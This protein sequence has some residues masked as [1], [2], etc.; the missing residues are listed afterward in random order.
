M[1][2]GHKTRY[3]SL[4]LGNEGGLG[5]EGRSSTLS[6]NQFGRGIP[7][8]NNLRGLYD[9]MF[10]SDPQLP[11]GQRSRLASDKR[12]LDRVLESYR[13]LKRK[14]GRDDSQKLEQYMQAMRDVEQE[15]QRMERWMATPN[16]KVSKD[17]LVLNASVQDPAATRCRA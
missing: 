7:S 1:T 2:H 15:I 3:P 11:K 14:L 12:R 16:P 13:D 17:D 10:N 5:G 4:V 8:S 6:Y 9:G